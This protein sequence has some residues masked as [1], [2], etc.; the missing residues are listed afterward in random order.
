MLADYCNTSVTLK[1]PSS[2]NQ[3]NEQSYSTQTI[4]ARVQYGN[5]V[6]I[7]GSGVSTLSKATIFTVSEI[8]PNDVIVLDSAD[9]KVISISRMNDVDGDLIGYEVKI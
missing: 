8:L 7:N 6:T 3:Y 2:T 5:T 1:R 9:W 4:L